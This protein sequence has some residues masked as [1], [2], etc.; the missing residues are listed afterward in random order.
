MD[1]GQ[2]ISTL[3]GWLFLLVTFS[4]ALGLAMFKGRQLLINLIAGVYLALLLYANFPYL[5]VFTKQAYGESARA[6]VSLFAFAV[7]TFLGTW[8]FSRLMP[9]EWLEGA[10][11]A[12]GKKLM[13]AVAAMVL[14]L[15]LATYFLPIGGLI[16]TGTPLPEWLLADKFAFLWL[17]L[18]LIALFLV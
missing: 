4:F 14:A 12:I 6:I 2:I 15:V 16:D 9:R 10:F 18:P 17:I 11:E 7:F 3:H 5:E 1:F 13:L 8:L